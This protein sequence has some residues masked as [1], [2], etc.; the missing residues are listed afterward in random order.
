MQN[1]LHI[2]N[3]L[4]CIQLQNQSKITQSKLTR[5]QYL[6]KIACLAVQEAGTPHR[7]YS[8]RK[9]ENVIFTPMLLNDFL[10]DWNQYVAEMPSKWGSLHTR[11]S[12]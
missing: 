8:D 7:E 2:M 6:V 11:K 10:S 12:P 1:L 3:D 5:K 9:K 4:L